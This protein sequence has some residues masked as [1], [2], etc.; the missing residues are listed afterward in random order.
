MSWVGLFFGLL[1]FA[2]VVRVITGRERYR[3]RVGP[4]IWRWSEW[5]EQ[6]GKLDA[7]LDALDPIFYAA[8][9]AIPAA[10]EW[11]TSKQVLER[12]PPS[13]TRSD[14]KI[15]QAMAHLVKCGLAERCQVG[16]LIRYRFSD[17]VYGALSADEWLT[18][19]E[20]LGRVSRSVLRSNLSI[21]LAMAYLVK[22]GLA[23]RQRE[24]YRKI[25]V[26]TLWSDISVSAARG[27][28]GR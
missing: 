2:F 26:S 13:V 23:E 11:L 14:W 19:K 28:G 15:R 24:R 8:Y 18:S 4:P 22:R 7:R 3:G 9:S 6:W 17:A 10:D 27:Q 21:Q 1:I 20:I 5:K 12:V 16:K 25:K